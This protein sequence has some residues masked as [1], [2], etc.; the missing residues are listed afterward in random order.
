MPLKRTARR[1]PARLARVPAS[2]ESIKQLAQAGSVV[3]GL[4]QRRDD[5]LGGG[6]RRTDEK[7]ESLKAGPHVDTTVL[8]VGAGVSSESAEVLHVPSSQAV[9]RARLLVHLKPP[10]RTASTVHGPSDASGSAG[11]TLGSLTQTERPHGVVDEPRHAS[12]SHTRPVLS[13]S[14]TPSHSLLRPF[15]FR[16]A[17]PPGTD[18]ERRQVLEGHLF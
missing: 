6:H 15:Y 9:L 16:V 1:A 7:T 10:S 17:D 4:E 5:Q 18:R 14:P 13:G 11:P 8:D 12:L 2:R 3:R